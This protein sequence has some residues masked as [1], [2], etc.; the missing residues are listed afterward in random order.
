[1]RPK[2][3]D[4]LMAVCNEAHT[5]THTHSFRVS[6]GGVNDI[7]RHVV[8]TQHQQLAKAAPLSKVSSLIKILTPKI[9]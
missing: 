6:H 3:R 1:M 4:P 8:S 7:K 9:W 2:E 5:H